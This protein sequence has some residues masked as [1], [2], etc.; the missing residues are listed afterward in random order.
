MV[1]YDKNLFKAS[2]RSTVRN[3]QTRLT[4]TLWGVFKEQESAQASEQRCVQLEKARR[5]LERQLSGLSDRLEEEESCSAQLVLHRDRLEVECGSLRR[6]VD[7]LDSALTAA[8]Q[9]KQVEHCVIF[10]T[11]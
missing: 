6:D 4:V 10:T 5:E 11:G 8:E 9:T 3:N 1:H 7:E 2:V